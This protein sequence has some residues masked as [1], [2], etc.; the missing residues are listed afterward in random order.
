MTRA[1]LACF[2]GLLLLLATEAGAGAP[3]WTPREGAALVG[4]RAPEWKGLRWLQGGPL[5]LAGL[6]GKVVLIRFWLAGCPFCTRTA[7][8]LNA[9]HERYA[10]R[11][12]V[13]IGIHHPKSE[14]AKDPG[15]VKQAA[16]GLGFA[17][18]I[19]QDNDWQTL[20][21]YGVG[22]TFQA[23]TSISILV[24]RNGV[25]RFV[26]DGGEYHPGGGPAHRECNAA[27]EALDAAIRA[28]LDERAQ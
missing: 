14:D 21:A 25:I 15:R 19:A 6:R 16:K 9:L 23:A 27:Y 17:F 26:H 10:D 12:L 13:V 7:P 1:A 11:G 20:E 28:A 3:A 5:T 4:T 22:S 2:A 18:P 8:A 24:G